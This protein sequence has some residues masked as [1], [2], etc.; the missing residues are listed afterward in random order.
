MAFQFSKATIL[1][2]CLAGVNGCTPQP[3]KY[4]PVPASIGPKIE[5]L[6]NKVGVHKAVELRYVNHDVVPRQTGSI[7]NEKIIWRT[8]SG[9]QVYTAITRSTWTFQFDRG[10]A[11][12]LFKMSIPESEKKLAVASIF[13]GIVPGHTKKVESLSSNLT[14]GVDRYRVFNDVGQVVADVDVDSETGQVKRI[15]LFDQNRK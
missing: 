5:A 2:L 14:P 10:A 9:S 4:Y 1:L 12:P 15:I 6:L 3:R 7:G 8:S 11:V 13:E